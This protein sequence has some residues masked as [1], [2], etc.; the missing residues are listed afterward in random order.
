MDW[1]SMPPRSPCPH[2]YVIASGVAPVL[3]GLLRA[4]VPPVTNRPLYSPHEDLVV[5]IPILRGC[6]RGPSAGAV[7]LL[8]MLQHKTN[9]AFVPEVRSRGG[10]AGGEGRCWGEGGGQSMKLTGALFGV[11]GGRHRVHDAVGEAADGRGCQG[12]D[13]CG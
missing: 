1:C 4:R 13:G 10:R 5:L 11:A 9:C 7:L 2:C 8:A 6:F 3:D 12:E